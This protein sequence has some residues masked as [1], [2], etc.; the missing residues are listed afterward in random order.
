MTWRKALA[1]PKPAAGPDRELREL[2]HDLKNEIQALRNEV[3]ELREQIRDPKLRG[4]LDDHDADDVVGFHWDGIEVIQGENGL[5]EVRGGPGVPGY[6]K[7]VIGLPTGEVVR[8]A[9]LRLTPHARL[10]KVVDGKPVVVDVEETG[11]LLLLINESKSTDSDDEQP[12]R[13]ATSDDD[14]DDEDDD[15]EDE[16]DG[17]EDEEDGDEDEED[18]DD[19]D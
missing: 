17:D 10:L 8:G 14:D 7:R 6:V 13:T 3:R 9:S 12:R 11:D 5:F 16:E 15:E 4:A 18:G 1:E 19:R 2:I